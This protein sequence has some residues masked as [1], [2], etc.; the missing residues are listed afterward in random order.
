M[1]HFPRRIRRNLINIGAMKKYTFYAIGE[2]VLVVIRI[3]IAL[4]INNWNEWKKDRIVEKEV[5]MNI[6][7]SLDV[8]YEQLNLSIRCNLK[9]VMACELILEHI[10]NNLSY[11]DSLDREFSHAIQWCNPTFRNAGYENLKSIGR[12]LLTNDSIK[13]ALDVY[14]LDWLHSLANRQD[15]YFYN[16]AAPILTEFFETVSHAHRNETF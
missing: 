6:K 7:K 11:H 16:T 4:Q 8:N 1:L 13:E 10:D 15:D 3:L 2:V 14:N 5:L 12:H 9:A